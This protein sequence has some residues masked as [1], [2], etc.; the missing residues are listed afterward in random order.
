[1]I[2]LYDDFLS[3]DEVEAALDSHRLE[4]QA[5]NGH[6]YTIRRNG[7]TRRWKRDPERYRIPFKWGFQNYGALE[8]AYHPDVRLRPEAQ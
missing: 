7:A 2:R 3:L 6:W 4:V 5:T 8:W 1:M